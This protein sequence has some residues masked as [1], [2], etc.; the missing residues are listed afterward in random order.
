MPHGFCLAAANEPERNVAAA[1]L[2]RM[3]G[4]CKLHGSEL[5][6]GDRGFAGHAFEQIVAALAAGLLPP[7]RATDDPASAPSAPSGDGS[8]RSSTPPKANSRSNVT[9]AAHSTVAGT[10]GGPAT[11]ASTS[12]PMA[13]EGKTHWVRRRPRAG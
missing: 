4:E 3:R 12:P 13:T 2:E 5:V 11:P 9:A 8:N 7:D 6:I 10:T 1:L